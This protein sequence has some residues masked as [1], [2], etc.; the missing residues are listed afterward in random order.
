M[1]KN[2]LTITGI[3]TGVATATS[4]F[5]ATLAEPTDMQDRLSIMTNTMAIA[6]AT[7]IFG[8]LDDEQ[9]DSNAKE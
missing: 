1:K 2:L 3:L 7:A 4:L 6:G 9:H 5:L 8:M